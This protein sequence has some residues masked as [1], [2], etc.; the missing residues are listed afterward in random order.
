MSVIALHRYYTAG[1][2][3]YDDGY[4]TAR[5]IAFCLAAHDFSAEKSQKL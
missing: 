1:I 5:N 3:P 4:L 2:L